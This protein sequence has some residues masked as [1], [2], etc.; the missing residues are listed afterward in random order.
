[1]QEISAQQVLDKRIAGSKKV[2]EN[3]VLTKESDRSWLLQ[4]IHKDGKPDWTYAAEIICLEGGSI[5]V[6]GDIGS[7]IFSYGPKD[8]LERLR[9]LGHCTDIGYY[10]VQKARIGMGDDHFVEEWDSDVARYEVKE[11]M[12]DDPETYVVKDEDYLTNAL[13]A[14]DRSEFMDCLA[15]AFGSNAWE[16][17]GETGM[18]TTWRVTHAHAA[19]ARL[20]QILDAGTQ[21]VTSV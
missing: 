16:W 11:R 15:K 19:I 17:I 8:P 2:F 21:Q 4:I 18:V 5:Y 9:W 13:D 12:K 10:V 14:E 20:C 3:H 1:M 6:G 7:M